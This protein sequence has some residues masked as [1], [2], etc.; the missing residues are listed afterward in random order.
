MRVTFPA[1]KRVG[2]PPSKP[3]AVG[4]LFHFVAQSCLSPSSRACCS[5]GVSFPVW[6]WS[7][8]KTPSG[9]FRDHTGLKGPSTN[10]PHARTRPPLSLVRAPSARQLSHG[11]ARTYAL[12]RHTVAPPSPPSA[13]AA[14]ARSD[15]V[16]SIDRSQRRRSSAG[17]SVAASSLLRKQGGER[18]CCGSSKVSKT[19]F[20]V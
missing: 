10:A 13:A 8:L 9:P 17:P 4:G 20:T 18:M 16:M 7:L 1:R 2:P 6:D 5:S 19:R 12:R 14:R 11:S 3:A 15:L